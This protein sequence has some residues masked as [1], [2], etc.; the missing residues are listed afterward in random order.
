MI[1]EIVGAVVSGTASIMAVGA[2]VPVA[3]TVTPFTVLDPTT[4][5][6]TYLPTSF[7]VN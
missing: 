5:D 7:A 1:L 3:D 4:I 2:D 6:L